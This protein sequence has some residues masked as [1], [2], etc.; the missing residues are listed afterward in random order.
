MFGSKFGE[1][2]THFYAVLLYDAQETEVLEAEQARLKDEIQSFQKEKEELEFILETHRSHCGPSTVGSRMMSVVSSSAGV[3][4]GLSSV[5][6]SA[7]ISL[8]AA[9]SVA[10]GHFPSGGGAAN[11]V[12]PPVASVSDV[13]KE[14][15]TV[16]SVVQASSRVVG[17]RPTSLPVMSG[18]TVALTMST[19][20]MQQLQFAVGLDS[21]ADGHTSLTPLT[22]IPSGPVLVGMPVAASSTS[23]GNESSSVVA[24]L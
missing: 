13:V 11:F 2:S 19:A 24:Y 16:T 12:V 4:V 1:L 10:G 23:G 6:V 3:S 9:A 5:P 22:G 20:G 8:M 21:L 17:A 18:R 15:A 14:A 7:D